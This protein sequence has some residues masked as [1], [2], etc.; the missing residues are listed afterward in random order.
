MDATAS[1]RVFGGR[2]RR[3]PTTGLLAA[4]VFAGVL[5]QGCSDNNGRITGTQSTVVGDAVGDRSSISASVTVSPGVIDTGRRAACSSI[6][7][8]PNGFPLPGRQ[9]TLAA[10]GGQPG[11]DREA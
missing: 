9:V 6:V 11:R 5:V 1:R 8:S 3:W 7:S 10:A 4:L 2:G